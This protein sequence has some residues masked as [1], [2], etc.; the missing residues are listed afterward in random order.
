MKRGSGDGGVAGDGGKRKRIGCGEVEG[1]GE[2]M[3]GVEMGEDLLFEVLRHADAATLG[4]A[5]C[6]SRPWR[7][8]AE[9]ERLWE[10]VCTRHWANLG[11]A[12]QQLRAV[13]LALGGFRRLHALYLRPLLRQP[14][15]SSSAAAAASSSFPPL[16]LPPIA[17]SSASSSSSAP[18][19]A[20]K[21]PARWGKDEVHLSLCLYSIRYFNDKITP[22][23]R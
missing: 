1:E 7:R 15:S 3:R 2:V 17:S 23:K 18:P 21:A 12:P 6:V 9:D 5:A 22:T 13:V 20:R 10:G 14:S 19:S 8:T 4:R 11:C 16:P